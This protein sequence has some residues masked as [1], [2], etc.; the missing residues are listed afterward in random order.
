[1]FFAV[2]SHA[3]P[4]CADPSACTAPEQAARDEV[5]SIRLAAAHAEI[6]VAFDR[7][8]APLFKGPTARGRTALEFAAIAAHET[9]L[10]PRYW[11]GDCPP[12]RCD[13]GKA[14]GEMQIHVGAYG[15]R[16]VGDRWVQLCAAAGDGCITSTDLLTDHEQPPRV[17]LHILRAGGLELYTGQ[18]IED[19]APR[20][21][22][23]IMRSWRATHP[24]PV[25]DAEVLGESEGD[26]E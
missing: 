22:L 25:T 3:A 10:Q 21:I 20:W 5:A 1:M 16:L 7:A 13:N 8:E 14:T 19:D 23:Q 11:R 12:G 26:G 6:A 15:V 4:P 24:V 17:A 9:G 2:H 18:G